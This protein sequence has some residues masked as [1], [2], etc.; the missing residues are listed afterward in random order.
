MFTSRIKLQPH[1]IPILHISPIKLHSTIFM[2]Q[3]IIVAHMAIETSGGSTL[4]GLD[5]H[6]KSLTNGRK[7]LEYSI[8][9]IQNKPSLIQHKYSKAS[10]FTYSIV[11]GKQIGR[12]HV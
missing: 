7:P 8:V 1:F 12:A 5:Y 4:I 6:R 10:M 3:E 11:T 2:A 9:T